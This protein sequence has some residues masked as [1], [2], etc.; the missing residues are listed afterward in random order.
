MRLTRN[1]LSAIR[2][3][4][5]DKFITDKNGTTYFFPWGPRKTGYVLTNIKIR[6]KYLNFYLRTYPIFLIAIA[7]SLFY[8]LFTNSFFFVIVCPPLIYVIWLLVHRQYTRQFVR[9][10]PITKHKYDDLVT[11]KNKS[12]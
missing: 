12:R 6:E 8:S 5:E 11:G 9:A 2:D 1:A 4:A 7:I 3:N 10:L